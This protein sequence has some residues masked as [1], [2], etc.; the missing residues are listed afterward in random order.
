M[1]TRR[2]LGEYQYEST[3]RPLQF[4]RT[5]VIFIYDHHSIRFIYLWKGTKQGHVLVLKQ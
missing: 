3:G 4:F 5:Q 1:N 2:M